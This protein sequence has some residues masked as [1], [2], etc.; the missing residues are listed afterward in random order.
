M[1]KNNFIPLVGGGTQMP[2]SAE[3]VADDIMRLDGAVSDLAEDVGTIENWDAGDIP[4]DS[5]ENYNDGT[6]GGS[7]ND[8]KSAFDDIAEPI[9]KYFPV[10]DSINLIDP[11]KWQDGKW[12]NA[13]GSIVSNDYG[14][15]V[16]VVNVES[17]KRL[18]LTYNDSSTSFLSTVRF[19]TYGSSGNVVSVSNGAINGLLVSD[20]VTAIAICVGV[21]SKQT[22]PCLT[23]GCAYGYI[24]Y[25]ETE[26]KVDVEEILN[27]VL[28]TVG[29]FNSIGAIGDSYTIASAKNSAGTWSNCPNQAY[30]AVLGK[31][32]DVAYANFGVSGANTRTYQTASGGL[33]AVLAAQANDFYFLALGINDMQLGASYIGSVADINDADYTQNADTFCGNYGKIIAQVKAHAPN[34]KF[35]MVKLALRPNTTA[36]DYCDAVDAIANHY[37]FPVIDQM[38][39]P[40]FFSAVWGTKNDS[41]PTPMGYVGM[42]LA[43]ERL[44]S[45]AIMQNPDYFEFSTI[46]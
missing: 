25:A 43:Y 24:P 2:A 15:T 37:G 23:Y 38:D 4:Y 21:A 26:R 13:D 35:C 6:V 1:A 18:Y 27:P 20:D 46:G 12:I 34:A 30:V 9:D 14:G 17:G 28:N 10:T 39:D 29:I 36:D 16:I 32:S 41:H 33:S 5:S 8:L 31:R 44:F 22:H 7:L 45:K 42:A 11:T 3:A 40:Y 19:A